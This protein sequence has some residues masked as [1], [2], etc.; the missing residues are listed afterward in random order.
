MTVDKEALIQQ[1][2]RSGYLKSDAVMNALR[3]VPREVFVSPAMKSHA[4][5]DRPL[6]I[7]SGQ[8]ISAPH[9]VAMMTEAL[10]LHPFHTVLE[11]GTGTGYH[12]AVVATVVSKGHVYTVERIPQLAEKARQNFH[13]LGLENITVVVADGSV[14]LPGHAPYDRIYATCS[15]PTVPQPLLDQLAG[16]GKMLVPVGSTYSNLL[17]IE[18]NE[19]IRRTNLGGCAF[20]PMIGMEGHHE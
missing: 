11:I 2:K 14:G 10:D 7:G 8:T 17:L 5:E 18:K 19:Q 4:Y 15:T 1:L 20:V 3:T 13:S 16:H 12:A 9:M 6:S